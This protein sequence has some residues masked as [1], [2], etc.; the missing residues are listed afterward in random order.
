MSQA[1]ERQPLY[2]WAWVLF[3]FSGLTG[4]IYQILWTRR[5]TLVFGHSILAVS[6]VVTAYMGGLALGSL[7]GGRWA[8]RRV[9]QGV[10]GGWYVR[11]Y[12]LLEGFVGLWAV[13]SL[14]LLDWIETLYFLLSKQGAQGHSVTL[15]VFALSLLAL[16]P[17]T[18]AMGATLPIVGCL[19]SESQQGVGVKLAR[20]YSIN[21]WGAVCGAGL[22]GFGMLPAI[23]LRSSIFLA[24]AVNLAIGVFAVNL[25]NRHQRKPEPR[26]IP[27]E[28]HSPSTRWLPWVFGLC[29]FSS[30]ALQLGWTRGLALSLGGAVYSFSAILVVFLSGIALGSLLYP[31]VFGQ[32]RGAV[33]WLQL[34]WLC[35]L[36]ALTGAIS[37]V[38]VGNLPLA[39]ARA[40][41]LV[42]DDYSKVLLLN[43]LVSGLVLLPPT[44]LM[45]LSFPLVTHLY[46]QHKGALGKSIGNVY[47]A[48][49]LG[50]I[51]GSFSAGFLGLP[52][53]GAENTLKVAVTCYLLAAGFSAWSALPGRTRSLTLSLA[54]CLALI[55]WWLPPW[56]TGL[57]SAGVAVY[58]GTFQS[59][60]KRPKPLFYQDG[61]TCNVAF[62]F[63][64]PDLPILRVNG[65]VDASLGLS[66]RINM[67]LTGLIPLLYTENP[68]RV[69]V[70]GLGGGLTLTS[71]A[72]S[73]KVQKV[74]CAELEPAV[75]EVQKYWAPYIESIHKNPKVNL[76]EADG[77]TFILGSRDPF[78]IIISEPSNPWIAGIGNL[79]TR[80][81]Y[82]RSRSS[83]AEDGVFLQWCNLYAVSRDDLRMV[84]RTFFESYEHGDI[85]LG[86]GDLMLI[87]SKKPLRCLPERLR[88]YWDQH[89]TL[90]YEMA[91][92]GFLQPEEVL[93]QFIASSDSARQQIG[94]GPINS[95]DRPLLEYSAPRSLYL[96]DSILYNLEFILKLRE[97]AQSQPSGFQPSPEERLR[98]R[99]G[100]FACIFRDMIKVAKDANDPPEYSALFDL[101]QQ[102]TASQ[103]LPPGLTKFLETFPHF[104]RARLEWARRAL[105]SDHFAEVLDFVG[106]DRYEEDPQS[107]Y[108]ALWLR[109]QALV[110]TQQ[111]ALAIEPLRQLY[112][113]RPLSK[114]ASDLATSYR[115]NGQKEEAK[116]WAQ[117]ALELNPYDCRAFLELGMERLQAKDL[118]SARPMLEQAV[119]IC[120]RLGEGW[121]QLGILFAQQGDRARAR[122]AV[123]SAI[124]FAPN[125]KA[126]QEL[127]DFLRNSG[128]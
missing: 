66:D 128:L 30:M 120:P 58:S 43:L 42:M 102:M 6:T 62:E 41:P 36:M 113:L 114:T 75:I 93:G 20:L 52:L 67:Y 56:N 71:V 112:Q 13:L 4:L 12:G 2:R 95:D 60:L 5:L 73:P 90:K 77:R 55:T 37:V 94:A 83:L 80:E 15:V 72:G 124:R 17:P 11:A 70:I 53:L 84:L 1:P 104:Q 29:G 126:A 118:A 100:T 24:A 28:G 14:V 25:G 117:Q 79:Y 61:L 38:L 49:T 106:T 45:G 64:A 78:D 19:F 85:W 99:L 110:S 111:W 101:L 65:K 108:L 47:G 82:Q 22:A 74:D 44:L 33:G 116:K 46:H 54:G 68:T 16:L 27:P 97:A 89:P 3:F 40:L 86:G 105:Q 50:C 123:E 21:T 92:L 81:F 76:M 103:P 122:R 69:G 125:A 107:H 63:E 8:D 121:L 98:I 91:E 32:G 48:N 7:L 18:M 23:G 26:E 59:L 35:L 34:A 39:F 31:R 119:Q 57:T 115:Q 109:S 88:D 10:S 51:L 96:R 127:E 9:R 87:G